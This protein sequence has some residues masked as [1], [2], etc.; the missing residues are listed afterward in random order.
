MTATEAGACARE[1]GVRRLV[2]THVWPR[3]DLATVEAR[4]SEAFEGEV[5]IAV[6]GMAMTP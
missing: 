1:A 5:S 3:N 4:A 6:E 2:I